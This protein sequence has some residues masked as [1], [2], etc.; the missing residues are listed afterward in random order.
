MS[1][2]V[3][4]ICHKEMNPIAMGDKDGYR[5]I[6][7]PACGSV[8]VDTW[9]TQDARDNFF[10]DIQPQITHVPNPEGEIAGLA[11]LL[12]K[13]TPA[14]Q[15]GRR[16]LD[17]NARNGYGVMAARGLGFEAQG[18]DAH[19]FFIEFAQ[20]TYPPELFTLAT[21]QQYAAE[22]KQAEFIFA[23]EAF[24]E[25]IDPDAFVAAIAKILTPGGTLY[26]EEPDGNSF[27]VPKY[28]PSWQIVFPPMNFVYFSKAGMKALLKR[29]GLKVQKTF[30]SWRP[31]MR[32]VI[33]KA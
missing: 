7:C 13:L 2:T 4:R 9:M 27:N 12:R 18:I 24:C 17:I 22:G 6:A 30:F 31:V 23:R 1:K 26:I 20:K 21:V 33:V 3:C 8:F 5:F 16:F 11:K 25:Q 28:F 32:M 10:G 15:A 14:G 29:H 19:D